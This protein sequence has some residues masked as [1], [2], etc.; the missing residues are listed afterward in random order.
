MSK[1]RTRSDEKKAEGIA[2]IGVTFM[3][4]SL[5][6][7]DIYATGG[8]IVAPSAIAAGF[9]SMIG[10]RLAFKEVQRK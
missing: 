6:F 1:F 2:M 10:A 8:S 3:C 4:A 5:S 9:L 7:A